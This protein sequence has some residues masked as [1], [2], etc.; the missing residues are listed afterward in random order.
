MN[1][2][3]YRLI[4][5]CTLQVFIYLIILLF[6]HIWTRNDFKYNQSCT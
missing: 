1:L 3:A 5:I 6:Y 2:Y 4:G